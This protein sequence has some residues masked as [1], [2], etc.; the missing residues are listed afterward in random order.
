ML[1]VLLDS[2]AVDPIALDEARYSCIALAIAD[3]WL[4]LI[5]THV[6]TDELAA[7]PDREKRTALLQ[8]ASVA[9]TDTAGFVVGSSRLGKAA[10][11]SDEEA[12]IY[13]QVAGRKRKHAND[14][15][16]L[17]TARRE[18]VPLV[19]NETR[20]PKFCRQYGVACWSSAELM[21]HLDC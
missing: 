15:M 12:T 11:T 14:A 4:E 3:Q 9:N 5:V 13:D 2:N 16:L 17:L 8:L 6:Q 20:L 19:T 18:N 7:T 10:L 21:T 1:R